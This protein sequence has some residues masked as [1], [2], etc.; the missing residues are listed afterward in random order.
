MLLSSLW[1]KKYQKILLCGGGRK[2]KLFDRT[3]QKKI[4]KDLL[5]ESIDNYGLNGDFIESQAF[6]FLATRSILKLPISFPI[7]YGV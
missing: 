6:A 7:D 5:L 4:S 2:I 1:T 3:Y